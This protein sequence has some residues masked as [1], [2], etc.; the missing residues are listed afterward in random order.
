M[1]DWF[2]CGRADLDPGVGR[3]TTPD[4]FPGFNTKP[5]TL[6][7]YQ[8]AVNNPILYTDPSGEFVWIVAGAA[9]G[10]G[11]DLGIQ[12]LLN[13]GNWDCV[14]WWSVGISGLA[15]AT[16]VGLG[17]GVA[18]LTA[19]L[20]VRVALNALG[21]GA[22]SFSAK[23]IQ[24]RVMGVDPMNGVWGAAFWGGLF[25]GA[26]TYVGARIESR[27]IAEG[28]KKARFAFWTAP[29]EEKFIA[30]SVRRAMSARVGSIG[31]PVPPWEK[32]G[33]AAGETIGLGLENFLEGIYQ[34]HLD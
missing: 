9:L 19:Q 26:G 27:A 32:F 11:I 6:H 17:A 28:A 10:A 2:T 31:H 34:L 16:G 29:P 24:N 23:Y 5:A 25:G 4:P 33:F 1:G 7:P 15:G 21:S 18:K 13:G 22:I 14:N 30:L 12:L 20:G 3:F 8:Y